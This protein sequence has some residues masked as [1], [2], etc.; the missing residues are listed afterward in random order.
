MHNLH[1]ANPGN[2]MTIQKLFTRITVIST[3]MFILAGCDP[4]L[5]YEYHLDNRSDSLLY[6]YYREAGLAG[7]QFDTTI[8]IE[9]LTEKLFY[10]T[11]VIGSNPHD[12]GDQFL[13]FFDSLSVCFRNG[14]PIAPVVIS[15]A[16]W[17]YENEISYFGLIKTGI[18]IYTLVLGNDDVR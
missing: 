15:R 12:E 13:G 11:W 5:G 2:I 6:L 4:G 9:P 10:E 7:S 17:K 8:T 3:F 18:N 16:T 1:P 14:E